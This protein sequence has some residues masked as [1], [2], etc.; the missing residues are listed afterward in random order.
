MMI[1]V[2]V[3]LCGMCMYVWMC[4]LGSND[5]KA[6]GATALAPHL[7]SLTALQTLK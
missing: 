3:V 4:S 6:A 1:C 5:L 2:S 7:A